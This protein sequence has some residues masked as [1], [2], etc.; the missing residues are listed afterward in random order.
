M[1]MVDPM[2][3]EA[4]ISSAP[5]PALSRWPSK[6]PEAVGS[7][8][9]DS[10]G[11]ANA[12]VAEADKIPQSV[13]KQGY[14]EHAFLLGWRIFIGPKIIM[15]PAKCRQCL[16]Y[17]HTRSGQAG[18]MCGRCIHDH[19]GCISPEEYEAKE[20]R[21]GQEAEAKEQSTKAKAKGKAK[22]KGALAATPSI[23]SMV[24]LDLYIGYRGKDRGAGRKVGGFDEECVSEAE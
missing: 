20:E 10:E 12:Q 18:R 2:F 22:D 7:T 16:H 5:C 23:S 3:V 9:K 4:D 1:F 17:G 6:E 13:V 19:Q 8:G 15:K 21:D 24:I 11:H 14:P